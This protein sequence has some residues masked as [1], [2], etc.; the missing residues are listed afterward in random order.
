MKQ[1]TLNREFTFRGKGLHTGLLINARF[2][3]AG[4]NTGITICRTDLPGRPVYK[5]VADYVS[6]TERGTVLENGNW[7]VSTVE[8]ALSA[9]YAMGVDNCLIEVD[10]PEFPILD[11]SAKYFVEAIQ[12]AG[13]QEQEAEQQVF[14]VREKLEFQKG[15][16]K[17]VISPDESY[18]VEVHIGFPSPVLNKQ[19]ASLDSLTEY[20]SAIAPARTF[21]FLREIQPL[22]Q[23]GLIKGGDLKNAIVIYDRPMTQH[24]FDEIADTLNQPRQDAANIGYLCPLSFDNEPA[25]HKLLDI[26][27]DLSLVGV[28]LQGRVIAYHP[29]HGVNTAF[30]KQLRQMIKKE[31]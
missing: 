29:G 21:V 25:R 19:S 7:R 31:N 2:L 27:G 12:Q 11:G 30:A 5:A 18:S 20:P 24:Q 22:L 3:P 8:H 13:L 23:M 4:V 15:D 28:R 1:H 26:I 14:V 9:L 6:A 17:I 10:A 16:S